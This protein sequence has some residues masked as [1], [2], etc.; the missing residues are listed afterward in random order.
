MGVG[1]ACVRAFAKL[2]FANQQL[3][4]M[5]PHRRLLSFHLAMWTLH[6]CLLYGGL[7]TMSAID[8]CLMCIHPVVIDRRG[9]AFVY[10]H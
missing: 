2:C 4:L 1:F 5:M 10:S 7:M 3:Y 6:C 8:C 9:I